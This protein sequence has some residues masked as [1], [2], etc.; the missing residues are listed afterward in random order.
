VIDC[1]ICRRADWRRTPSSPAE[2]AGLTRTSAGSAGLRANEPIIIDIFPLAK[3]R[4]LCDITRTVGAGAQNEACGNSTTPFARGQNRVEKSAPK[5]KT[6]RSHK[7]SRNFSVPAGLQDGRHNG[8]MEGF[9]TAPVTGWVWKSTRRA[10]ESDSTEVLRPG[11]VVTWSRDS[12]IDRH[13][14]RRLEDVALV[15]TNGAKNLTA[16]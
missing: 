4:L 12:T 9:F 2:A 14:R 3:D 6:S 5:V 16:L 7:S 15:T 1:A 13:R 11:H 10:R 8:R